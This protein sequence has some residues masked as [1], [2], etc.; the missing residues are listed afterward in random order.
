MDGTCG[1]LTN[2]GFSK[3]T[4]EEERSAHGLVQFN[5]LTQSQR[6]NDSCMSSNAPSLK[7]LSNN[8]ISS[9][10][11]S[12][13]DDLQDYMHHKRNLLFAS[14]KF[15]DQAG[16]SGDALLISSEEND[17]MNDVLPLVT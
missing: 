8:T 2:S 5:L 14:G 1:T 7:I 4:S 10:I 13:G 3:D 9:A 11:L 16:T 15:A 17:M 12:D 6:E